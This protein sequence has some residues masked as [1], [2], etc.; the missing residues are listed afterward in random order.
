M[1]LIQ[2]AAAKRG[3]ELELRNGY[4]AAD[5]AVE[6]WLQ[7]PE[8]LEEVHLQHQATRPRAFVHFAAN[9][10]KP[11][12]LKFTKEQIRAV[13][14]R[15]D[16]WY[17]SKQRG[18][19]CR[20]HAFPNGSECKFLVRHGEPCKREPAIKDGESTSVFYRPEKY[21]L[22]AY[23]YAQGE[24][25]INC[26]GVTERHEL[27]RAFGAHLFADE[28]FFPCTTKYTLAPLLTGRDCLV[29]HD[30]EGLS[31]VALASV[32]ISH[33]AKPAFESRCKGDDVFAVIEAG[34]WN[35]PVEPGEIVRAAFLVTFSGC[36]TPRTVRVE[37]PNKISYGRDEDADVM[38]VW[39]RARG[40]IVGEGLRKFS[41]RRKPIQ[42]TLNF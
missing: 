19:G 5:V 27:R 34:R 14:E 3:V 7:A 11:I 22:V 31:K 38:E 18:R 28:E 10:K 6:A 32:E 20:V 40:F 39:M 15:L 9:E 23:D 2:D 25:R 24:L 13:E 35:W 21:D 17:A 29:C 1:E 33:P 37:L 16:A 8:L 36:K 42:S 12:E 4:T 41:K 30:I 26:A